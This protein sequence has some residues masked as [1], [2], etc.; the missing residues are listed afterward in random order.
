MRVLQLAV[1]AAAIAKDT[2]A[3]VDTLQQVSEGG[4]GTCMYC[5]MNRPNL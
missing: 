4:R 5:M 1:E 3:I 2:E